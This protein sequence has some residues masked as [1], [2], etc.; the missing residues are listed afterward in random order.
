[1]VGQVSSGIKKRASGLVLNLIGT[2]LPE[3]IRS[4]VVAML[5]VTTAAGLALVLFL[6]QASW[7]IPSL[8]PL[9]LPKAGEAGLKSGVA[10]GG[11][12]SGASSGSA[13]FI[14]AGGS[15]A[16]S[17]LIVVPA[18]AGGTPAAAGS[19]SGDLAGSSPDVDQGQGAVGGSQAT[20]PSPASPVR[21]PGTATSGAEAQ[22]E[23]EAAPVGTPVSQP[24]TGPEA[25]AV[26]AGEEP[27]FEGEL[28]E[29]EEPPVE[30]PPVEE[31][32]VEEPPVEEPEGGEAGGA[33]EE[34]APEEAAD[35]LVE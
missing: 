24:T 33:G 16:A 18:G 3:R 30:E 12:G 13:R 22:D 31:P 11:S 8:G 10:L 25:P 5:G 4:T 19:P 28:P 34:E 20:N 9:T 29:I 32:P 21:Q 2:G 27:P 6:Y 23:P 26:P 35:P 14:G 17:T 15:G 7:P 1:M